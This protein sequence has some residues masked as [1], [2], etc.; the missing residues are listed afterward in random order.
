MHRLAQFAQR[1]PAA[2]LSAHVGTSPMGSMWRRLHRYRPSKRGWSWSTPPRLRTMRKTRRRIRWCSPKQVS[3]EYLTL[4]NAHYCFHAE[5]VLGCPGSGRWRS[6]VG[7]PATAKQCTMPQPT[8]S[9]PISRPKYR[10]ELPATLTIWP[11]APGIYHAQRLPAKHIAA[12][13]EGVPP[14]ATATIYAAGQPHR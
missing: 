7:W 12:G 3:L 10:C 1:N 6:R 11:W 4:L 2:G 5:L 8:S 14:A 13:G 9:T